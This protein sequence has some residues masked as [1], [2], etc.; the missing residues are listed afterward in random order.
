M[1]FGMSVECVIPCN[2]KVSIDAVNMGKP[3]T[4]CG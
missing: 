3:L 2:D 4:A 1:N